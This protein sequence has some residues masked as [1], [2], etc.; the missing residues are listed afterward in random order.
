MRPVA[1]SMLTIAYRRAFSMMN[2]GVAHASLD[3]P[4]READSAIGHSMVQVE[5]EAAIGR[6]AD[7]DR[8]CQLMI[9]LLWKALLIVIDL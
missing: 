4:R 7:N 2:K 3:F 6:L 9:I 1:C 8:L 5:E